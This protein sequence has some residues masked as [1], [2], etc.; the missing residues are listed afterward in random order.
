MGRGSNFFLPPDKKIGLCLVA[1]LDL[2]IKNTMEE[3][4]LSENDARKHISNLE[5]KH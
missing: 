3:L 5:K 1:P 2:R 4:K